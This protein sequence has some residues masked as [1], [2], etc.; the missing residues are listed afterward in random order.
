[1]T[2]VST[3]CIPD[4]TDWSC[5]FNETEL[6]EQDPIMIE[7]AEA[8][9]WTVLA[10]LSNYRIATCPITVR[11]VIQRQC[12]LPTY[13]TAIVRGGDARA[14]GYGAGPFISGGQWFNGCGCQSACHCSSIPTVQLPGPIGA[15]LS[16]RVDGADLPRSAYRVVAGDK[17]VRTDG[18]TWPVCQDL[19]ATDADG[20]TVTYYRGA[21]PNP[22]TRRAAGVLANEFLLSCEGDAACRLPNNLRSASRQGESYDFTQIDYAE[23]DTGIPEVQAIIRIFN[24][25]KLTHPVI[26]ASPDD[27]GQAVTTWS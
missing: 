14:L 27:Y 9:G 17:L 25:N 21:A 5:R 3:I 1:M 18:G 15:I 7:V 19:T 26:V 4:G 8:F 13:R 16:V 10:A 23:G 6:A 24:P 2:Y 11:P 22:M 20:F 12:D